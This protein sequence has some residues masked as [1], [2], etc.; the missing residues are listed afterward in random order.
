MSERL[1][2]VVQGAFQFK[3]TELTIG[4]LGIVKRI[5]EALLTDKNEAH[6]PIYTEQKDVFETLKDVTV[7]DFQQALQWFGQGANA[8]AEKAAAVINLDD[9]FTSLKE[10]T[11]GTQ[12]DGSIP[13]PFTGEV[14]DNGAGGDINGEGGGDK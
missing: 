4:D 7:A 5:E 11:D 12:T 6:L 1:A 2:N 8:H 3:A 13:S 9:C 14:A 10:Q